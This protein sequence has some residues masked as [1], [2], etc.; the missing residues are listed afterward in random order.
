MLINCNACGIEINLKPSYV[1]KTKRPTC[2]YECYYKLLRVTKKSL[3]C[4]YCG[5]NYFV[6]PSTVK[7]NKLRGHK[8]NFCTLTCSTSFYS[9]ENAVNWKGGRIVTDREYVL[10]QDKGTDSP[11]AGSY[12]YEHRRVMEVAIGRRLK[13]K[14][15]V[16]HKDGNKLNN[17]IDNLVLLTASEHARLHNGLRTRNRFGQFSSEQEQEKV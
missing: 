16:H 14:E 5:K 1:K 3:V 6:P 7:W 13:R 9:G 4:D 8:R 12:R 10:V 15:H 17:N 2:S 11:V